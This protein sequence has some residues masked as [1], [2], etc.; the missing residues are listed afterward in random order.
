MVNT[1]LQRL[2]NLIITTQ[3]QVLN[4]DEVC[5][6]TGLSKSTIYKCTMNGSIPHFKKLKHLYFD[7]DEI[8]AW[9]KERRGYNA[10]EVSQS[11]INSV[12]M[13]GGLL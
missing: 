8:I 12:N 6:Y 10:E 7:R 11:A 5:T 13:K 2:E 3:K 9:L 1:D 4:I